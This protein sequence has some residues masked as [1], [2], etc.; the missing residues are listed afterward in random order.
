MPVLFV[1]ALKVTGSI[2]AFYLANGRLARRIQIGVDR[3]ESDFDGLVIKTLLLYTIRF[4]IIL[5]AI[6]TRW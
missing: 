5:V 3:Q 2:L 4:G 1:I 6:W